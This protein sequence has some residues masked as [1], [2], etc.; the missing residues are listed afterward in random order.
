MNFTK[1][2]ALGIIR[3]KIRKADLLP[4]LN[5]NMIKIQMKVGMLTQY[6]DDII[7]VHRLYYEIKKCR[8][9]K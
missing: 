5:S 7:V 4:Y 2:Q 3:D 8:D 1:L 6:I 9:V